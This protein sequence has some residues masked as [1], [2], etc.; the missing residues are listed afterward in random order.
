MCSL[1]MEM[2]GSIPKGAGGKCVPRSK[3]NQEGSPGLARG[4]PL[5]IG[6]A[7]FAKSRST[8]PTPFSC[9]NAPC[10]DKPVK[11]PAAP[12][13]LANLY[14]SPPAGSWCGNTRNLA[15]SVGFEEYWQ[16]GGLIPPKQHRDLTSYPVVAEVSDYHSRGERSG[17][18]HGAA[19]VTDLPR[20]TTFVV[21]I[22]PF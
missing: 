20:N 2:T 8:N 17:W 18:I 9:R 1:Q 21:S 22:K 15:G 7:S 12:P 10:L 5:S 19:S 3:W 6:F 4:A 11:H 14:I 16:F 13:L